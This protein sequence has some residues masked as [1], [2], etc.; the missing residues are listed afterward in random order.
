M[1][2]TCGCGEALTHALSHS[3][4]HHDHPHA[5]P[6]HAHG[7]PF[8]GEHTHDGHT[9]LH[10][11]SPARTV[12]VENDLLAL[13]HALAEANR[14]WLQSYRIHAINLISSPGSGKTLLLEKTLRRLQGRIPTA[15]IVG[16]LQTDLD[17]QRLQGLGARVKQI[18]TVN[19]CHLD[20]E[21]VSQVLPGVIDETTRLLFIENV[22]NLVCPAAFDLGESERV[23]LLSTPEGEDKPLKYPVPF[24]KASLVLVTK[25][26]LIPHLTWKRDACLDALRRV[27]P[28]ASV[29]ELSALTGAGMDAWIRHLEQAVRQNG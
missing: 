5:H 24:V 13:N 7:D 9:H 2:E 14:R 19:A 26:D 28:A 11:P 15:V 6:D 25:T 27:N 23:V 17:A 22:G 8:H 4:P 20:A 16:D 1:C 3:D 29:L 10:P 21:R 18:E 12:R